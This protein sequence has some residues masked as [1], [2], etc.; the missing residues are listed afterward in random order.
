MSSQHLPSG[1][2]KTVKYFLTGT[3]TRNSI[4]YLFIY[5]VVV[6]SLYI[7]FYRFFDFV[8]KGN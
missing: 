3:I 2:Q 1:L 8:L 6:L 5:R 7:L 4:V